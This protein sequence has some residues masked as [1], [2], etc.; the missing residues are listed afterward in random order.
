MP[1]P[2]NDPDAAVPAD[3]RRVLANQRDLFGKLP[4]D[5]PVRFVA[6][7]FT[8]P[9]DG[10]TPSNYGGAALEDAIVA[11]APDA[12]AASI[13]SIRSSENDAISAS[14]RS[15][16]LAYAVAAMAPAA[17][18]VPFVD[19]AGIAAVAAVMLRTLARRY[20]IE[21]TPR[22]FGE[23]TASL[24]T[25]VLVSQL[26]KYGGNELAKLVPFVGLALSVAAAFAF[27]Y[28]L[29]TAACVYLSHRRR[30]SAGPDAAVRAAFADAL[31]S[32]F[33]QAARFR[34][35]RQTRGGAV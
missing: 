32:G 28:A 35:G 3:L 4:G 26:V 24:G 12:L 10:F 19:A 9:E 16:V 30:G 2:F 21:W 1:Y 34:P 20:D 18:P 13:A 25:S 31:R 17:V 14:S 5:G 33:E 7:D 8:L 23:F 22:S 15:L 29:G 11:I 27:T 6:I